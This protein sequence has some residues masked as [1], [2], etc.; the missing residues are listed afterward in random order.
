MTSTSL[1]AQ[2]GRLVEYLRGCLVG[3]VG[4]PDE[5]IEGS[6]FL[7][8]MMG[9]LFPRGEDVE[10]G[11]A[12]LGDAGVDGLGV[13]ADED[14]AGMDAS[15]DLE[16]ELLPSVVG[17]SFVVTSGS[18]VACT[19]AAGRYAQAL[20]KE[21]EPRA[22][23][24]RHAARAGSQ[25]R[26]ESLGP[27]T[28][29]LTASQ[30]EHDVLGGRA[31]VRSTWR[32]WRDEC[33]LVTVTLSNRQASKSKHLE[34][35]ITLFQV[36]LTCK[37]DNG[38]ILPYP[39]PEN[40]VAS[41]Q[42]DEEVTYLYRR[43]PPYARG[44]GAAADWTVD[45]G[46]CTTAW[47]SFMPEQ[48]VPPA[49]FEI[50]G[51]GA[52]PR[53]R[54]IAFLASCDDPRQLREVLAGFVSGY[55][56]WVGEQERIAIE[57]GEE[58][59]QRLA[60]RAR[61]WAERME[62]GL[63]L[64]A[65]DDVRLAFQLANRAMGIQMRLSEQIKKGP[66]PAKECK[67]P[68]AHQDLTGLQW[69]PFQVAF[70]L[71]VLESLVNP[72]SADRD[73]VDVIWFPTGGGKT[74]AYLM[75]AAF[76]LIRRRL[77]HGDADTA[78]AVISRYTL[79]MLTTQ[80]FERTGTLVAGLE[81]VRATMGT[82]LGTRPFSLGLWVGASLSHNRYAKAFED[83]EAQRIADVPTNAKFVLTRCPMCGT[84][85]L[86]AVKRLPEAHFGVRAK[87]Q[88]FAYFCPSP[89]C[90][91]HDRIPLQTVD[92]ALYEDPPSILL[93]TLDKF[94]ALPWNSRPRAFFG[95]PGD[96]APPPS[97]VIQ[98]ELHL[99]SGPLGSIAAPYDVAIDTVIRLRTGGPG[100][101][102]IASTATIRN[103]AEQV[104]GLYGRKS[105]VFPMPVRT[106][107]DAYFFRLDDSRPGRL[108]VGV[109]GQGY[110]S[111]TV[112]AAWAAAGILQGVNEVELDASL[113]DGYWTLLSYM[114]SRR[115]L[116][117]IMNA[118]SDE[119]PTR[120]KVIARADDLARDP[121]NV[122][123]LSS[124]MTRNMSEALA[125][126][127]RP[128]GE[129]QAAQDFVA[130]TSI[131]SVGVDVDRLGVM[132]MNGQPKLTSEYIQA[133]SRVG[134]T[135]AVPGLV[136][137]L[138]SASKPRDRSHYEDF[139]AYHEALYRF[140]EPT[141]VTPYAPPARARTLHAALVTLVRHWSEWQA[142]DSAPRAELDAP[143]VRRAID[144]MLGTMDSA[145]PSESSEVRHQL[146][147][148]IEDWQE[149]AANN[150]LYDGTGAG[151]QFRSLLR[152]FTD[153]PAKGKWPTMR[154]VRNVDAEVP[155]R[156]IAWT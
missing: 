62:S 57:L 127:A 89:A 142:N 147:R 12:E 66:F 52:D 87:P 33:H 16:D 18:T 40:G 38:A 69:R 25:W 129:A 153:P 60:R 156:P 11:R 114:N 46:T 39:V 44:H 55:V 107:D 115:E 128:I 84:A 80:Q 45:G 51:A 144:M 35:D 29:V 56:A 137:T 64:I 36:N 112:A 53:Y 75:V 74:E 24:G 110:V 95:G 133:T 54:D 94:A 71:G 17:L 4:G 140:V 20:K 117:R 90:G 15:L 155:L 43:C 48:S 124:Q 143:E 120:I 23:K 131:I 27:E 103:A 85:I 30:R 100:P 150:L 86:P 135:K 42:E 98:D 149:L 102:V 70:V 21:V 1:I 154:S 101:K 65:G 91:F 32:R 134:R 9:M 119:I 19:V 93:G 148:L 139:K 50:A 6:P 31:Q 28:V 88:S 13:E 136:V 63:A 58:V 67:A 125:E 145:D 116:G 121:S 37:L 151:Q 34:P 109:M 2:R 3:P 83:L 108:Y 49:T 146:E 7:R 126:L 73:C 61:A 99:I 106:W 72:E 105:L 123:E 122:M 76:E 41:Q 59:G 111:P 82:K 113:K 118:A 152:D 10:D 5:V 47:V 81:L 104:R 97:L 78:T 68:A 26:R 14:G 8:Y 77:S 130:C 22:K 141:S 79:R 96:H 92:D 138:Y 132:Q